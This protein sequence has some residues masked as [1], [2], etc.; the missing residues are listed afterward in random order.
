[1]IFEGKL[2]A[3]DYDALDRILG[4]Q[5]WK[6]VVKF[7]G[8]MA[9]EVAQQ[10][11]DARQDENLVYLKGKADGAKE[12]HQMLTDFKTRFRQEYKNG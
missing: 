9:D 5:D 8:F 4:D 7:V 1:M 12:L 2:K 3:E 10:I 11:L 6:T